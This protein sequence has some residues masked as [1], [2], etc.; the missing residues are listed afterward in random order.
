MRDFLAR[1]VLIQIAA[2]GISRPDRQFCAF[3]NASPTDTP[4]SV[5]GLTRNR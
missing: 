2:T 1:P 3:R 4:R 5:N